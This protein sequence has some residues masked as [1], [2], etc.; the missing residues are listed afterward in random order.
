MARVSG[1]KTNGPTQIDLPLFQPASEALPERR[2]PVPESARSAVPSTPPSLTPAASPAAAPRTPFRVIQGG[3]ERKH[4]ALASRD[5]VVRVLL[6]AG[7]DLLLRRISAE[8]ADEIERK[9]DRILRLF[10]Q[11][12][13][14]PM[15]MPV[16][17]R[18]LD[19]LEAL[20]RETRQV[21]Q[22]RR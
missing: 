9:V 22:V 14:A 5:A 7:A 19:D 3:G 2:A 13:G 18:Q 6:E 20:M 11:V 1:K 15:L 4:E 17:Q 8:R 10:D 21:R 12:D 16:L